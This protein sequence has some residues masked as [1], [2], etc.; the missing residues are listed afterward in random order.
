MS[1]LNSVTGRWP[2]IKTQIW[3]LANMRQDKTR[4]I[5]EA[6]RVERTY[7][8]FS[9]LSCLSSQPSHICPISQPSVWHVIFPIVLLSCTLSLQFSLIFI[10]HLPILPISSSSFFIT[11]PF[12]VFDTWNMLYILAL[13]H[14]LFRMLY[15]V[16]CEVVTV[17]LRLLFVC[18]KAKWF[19]VFV[20]ESRFST[21]C[22]HYVKH[23][24]VVHLVFNH[25]GMIHR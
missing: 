13:I 12:E 22:R 24:L 23:W 10:A 8:D 21:K 1:I 15:S 3:F 7:I 11:T 14:L 2:S 4:Y 19:C 17:E 6:S 25:I 9:L 18:V 16:T 5:S 20:S